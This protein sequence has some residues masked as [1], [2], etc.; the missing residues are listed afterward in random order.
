MLYVL[1]ILYVMGL[2]DGSDH[3][4]SACDVGDL[5]LITGFRRF[6]GE[7]NGYPLQNSGLENSTV[8]GTWQAT[9]HGITKSRTQ[10]ND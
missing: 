1:H 9:L 7:A 5:G 6:P 10:L 8:R 2:P 3:K 4:E